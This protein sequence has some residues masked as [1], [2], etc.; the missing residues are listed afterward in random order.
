MITHGLA[1]DHSLGLVPSESKR[2][3]AVDALVGNFLNFRKRFGSHVSGLG[4]FGGI[5][6]AVYPDPGT[7]RRMN[8]GLIF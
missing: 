1:G 4:G 8:L 5:S 3:F 6:L 7:A 2:L